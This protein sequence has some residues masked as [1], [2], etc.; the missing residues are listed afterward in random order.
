MSSAQAQTQHMPHSA[1]LKLVKSDTYHAVAVVSQAVGVGPGTTISI[2]VDTSPTS[3]V[4]WAFY[5]P[6]E[7]I[8]PPVDRES[9][10]SLRFPAI[11][12]AGARVSKRRH[13]LGVLFIGDL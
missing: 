2:I 3:F 11:G 10:P 1:R 9:D 8:R 6:P 12:M 13:P 7:L 4:P 5:S